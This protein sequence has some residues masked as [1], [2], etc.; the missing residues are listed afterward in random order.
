MS[1]QALT[2][3]DTITNLVELICM[4]NEIAAYVALC[5][6]NAWLAQYPKP[7]KCI[8]DQGGEFMGY[9]FQ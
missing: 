6:E 3:I 8:H 9:Y 5:F 7:T 4:D 2:I 1:F